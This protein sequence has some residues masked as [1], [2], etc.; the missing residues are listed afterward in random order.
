MP[1]TITDSEIKNAIGDRIDEAILEFYTAQAR[2]VQPRIHRRWVLSHNIGETAALLRATSG[3]T[4][5]KVH[6]W[7]IGNSS[8]KR[9]RPLRSGESLW[10]LAS[11]GSLKTVGPDRRD[12]VKS[13]RI[14]AYTQ[15]DTGDDD[16]NSEN[17]LIAEIEYVA[18]YLSK[19]PT[20]GIST[21]EIKGHSEISFD[22]IDVF[23]YGELQV[24]V[25]QGQLDLY[26]YETISG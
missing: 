8:Y 1:F 2:T 16:N 26:M 17:T 10:T 12:I 19:F 25:A 18:N 14:W 3:D 22:P 24:N 7:M 13:Y 20:L 5:G 4:R 9:V 11:N 6:A 23:K 15:L 21:Q